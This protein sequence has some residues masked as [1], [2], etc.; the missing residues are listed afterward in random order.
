MSVPQKNK[1]SACVERM[2]AK[3]KRITMLILAALLLCS[4]TPKT[5]KTGKFNIVT[6]IFPQY[7]FAREIGG[8]SAEYTMLIKP[9]GEVHTYEPSPADIIKI[10]E[11][12]LFICVGGESETWLE[13]I[14]K[15]ADI[16]EDKIIRIMDCVSDKLKEEEHDEYDEHVWT[17]PVNAQIISKAITDKMCELNEENAETYKQNL[18]EYDKKLQKLDSDFREIVNGAE[19]HTIMVADRFP[20]RYLTKEYGI[21]YYSA[22]EGCSEESEPSPAKI[23]FL[24]DK[25]KEEK[26]P[27]VFKVD[28]SNGKIAKTV[29][30]GTDAKILCLNSCHTV[31]ADDFENNTTYLELMN[32]NLKNIGEA[33]K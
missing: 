27:V 18:N 20:M 28:F 8:E 25:L 11:C 29:T 10:K 2:I 12:D 24:V 21:E 30:E 26:L 14:I 23:A 9:G 22:F 15:S 19:K 13:K 6:T 7:D 16:S 32:E 3:M 1:F 4:C 33:L 31:S 5:E 17:S